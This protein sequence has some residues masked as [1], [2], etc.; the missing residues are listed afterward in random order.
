M[1]P[2]LTWT[3]ALALSI[4][5]ASSA[6]MKFANI[7]EFTAALEDYR[8]L[9]T[10]LIIPAGWT[11][12]MLE[13]AGALGLLANRTRLAAALLLAVLVAAF[14][15]AIVINLARGRR[16]IDCG[17]FGPALRQTLSGWLVGR[18]LM[19]VVAAVVVAIPADARTIG[20]IDIVTISFGAVTLALFYVSMNHL[21]AN[22]PWIRE[23]G[24]VDG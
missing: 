23:L 9:P 12:P 8:I 16:Q 21:L 15:A 14:S 1:D 4:I 11:I 22:A 18:N 7:A 17:C 3:F 20:A 2:V 5:F 13:A 6:A 10:P 24:R 19:L